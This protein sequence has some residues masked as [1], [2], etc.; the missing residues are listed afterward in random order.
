MIERF[1]SIRIALKFTQ[2][3]FANQLDGVTQANI[4]DIERGRVKIPIDILYKLHE[5]W[6]ININWLLSGKGTM[7][8]NSTMTV[9]TEPATPYHTPPKNEKS[10]TGGNN[11]ETELLLQLALLR[12]EIERKNAEIEQ[13]K[14]LVNHKN[15]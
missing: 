5:K 3:E 11:L 14:Q 1:K 8:I 2:V 10:P 7:F 12:S 4:T 9:V 13:L 15:S 6:N